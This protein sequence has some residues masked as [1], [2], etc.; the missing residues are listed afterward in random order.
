[1]LCFAKMGH[2][3][4]AFTRIKVYRGGDG[5]KKK[6][7]LFSHEGAFADEDPD[8]FLKMLMDGTVE[9]LDLPHALR[10][11]AEEISD[12]IGSHYTPQEALK[13][14]QGMIQD[15]DTTLNAEVVWS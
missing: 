15:H 11:D 3:I 9:R 2:K 10:E 1:M 14:L 7:R 5:N 6:I 13:V 4:I 8:E 12:R